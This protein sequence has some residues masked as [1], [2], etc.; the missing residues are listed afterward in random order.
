[1]EDLDFED[2][3]DE[4]Y[5]EDDDE[6][7]TMQKQGDGEKDGAPIDGSLSA[8]GQEDN[9][10]KRIGNNPGLKNNITQM[11]FFSF[12][13]L[14]FFVCLSSVDVCQPV[15]R[16]LGLFIEV[17]VLPTPLSELPGFVARANDARTVQLQWLH[18]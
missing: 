10:W 18:S 3:D 2:S 4:L 15:C 14:S 8:I 9:D 1:M 7:S 17:G 13:L 11:Y 5:K 12:L 6:N 16:S